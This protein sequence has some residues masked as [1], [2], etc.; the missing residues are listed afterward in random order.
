[1]AHD[2][3]TLSGTEV[4]RTSMP[5][6]KRSDHA[7]IEATKSGDEAAF[8]EIMDRY[9]SPITNYLYRFLNDYE[10][11]VDLA[12]E[13]FVRV[14]FAIDRYHT[15][16][17]FSTYIY[18]I[19]TNLAISEIR[20]RK[21]RRLM[22][23]TGLFQSED[24]TQVEFQPPDK[25]KLQDIELVDDERSQV[26]ARAIAALPEKYRIPVILRDIEGRS[27]DE[28]AEIMQLGLGTTKSRINRG[29]GLLKEKLQHYL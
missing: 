28:I 7:L 4:S 20:R 12:Q 16:F 22:S 1:M 6:E 3:D 11:A 21:R 14:Y 8:G 26:I 29:R 25:R 27:Y 5:E 19:A 15:Q 9:R 17:A 18:R 10:E 2:I 13:T 23:L 24:D